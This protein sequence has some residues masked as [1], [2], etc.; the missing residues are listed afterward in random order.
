[1]TVRKTGSSGSPKRKR[2]PRAAAPPRLTAA[3]YRQVI[4]LSPDAI[5]IHQH[6]RYVYANPAALRL[7]GAAGPSEMIGTSVLDRVY[8]EDRPL[9]QD[10]FH[11]LEGGETVGPFVEQRVLRLDG[12]LIHV[13]IR[14]TPFSYQG[15]PAILAML[16]DVTARKQIEQAMRE[17][18]SKFRVLAETLP[19]A[20]GIIQGERFRYVNPASIRMS[21]YSE[22][23]LLQ[24]KYWE[25]AH[26]DYRD[27][28]RR[29]GLGRQNGLSGPVNYEIQMLTKQG[30]TAWVD[31]SLGVIEYQGAPAIIAA[32]FDITA[33]RRV[34]KLQA[35]VYQIAQAAD[36]AP[37][38]DELYQRIHRI[39]SG[40]MPATNFYIALYNAEQNLI[41][42]PYFVDEVDV[43]LPPQAPGRGMTEYVLRTGRSLLVDEAMEAELHRRGEVELVGVPSPIWLGVPLKI[44]EQTIGV[45]AVQH[46]QN[47]HAYGEHEKQMLEFVSSQVAQAIQRKAETLARSR[48]EAALIES[49]ERYRNLFANAPVGIYRTT[50]DGRILAANP[51]LLRMVGYGS[52]E[53]LATLNLKAGGREVGYRNAVFEQMIAETGAV[54]GLESQWRTRDGREMYISENAQAIRGPDG[55]IL[56]YDGTVEDITERKQI[57]T[58]EHEQR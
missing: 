17:S 15:Q 26:P 27:L 22:S 41:T 23:E 35:A 44:E 30:Q 21:G 32:S 4:E 37:S 52:F 24:M 47:P 51:T 7:F 20:I 2:T 42:F 43:P 50:P 25:V 13:E 56:Y 40:V 55:Q 46:Y 49:E 54:R 10:R 36:E 29:R 6:G 53:E 3:N 48:T 12:I 11:H 9:V 18:E 38:L 8:P 57:E 19:L 34:E 28:L 45:M 33:R 39:I 16:R 14:V 5:V 31:M 1:M 58:A